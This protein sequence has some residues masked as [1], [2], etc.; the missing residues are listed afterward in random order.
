MQ[1]RNEPT[2]TDT[3][4]ALRDAIDR[5]E[6]YLAAV[7]ADPS[8]RLAPASEELRLPGLLRAEEL[9]ARYLAFTAERN[10]TI[11][12]AAQLAADDEGNAP[13]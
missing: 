6:R 1:L 4:P 5:A 8:V 13:Q 3:P 9:T 7:A 12:A 11:I 10:Q 2:D